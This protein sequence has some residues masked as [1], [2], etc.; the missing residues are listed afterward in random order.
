M[1]R[2]VGYDRYFDRDSIFMALTG[3]RIRRIDETSIIRELK[4]NVNYIL[5]WNRHFWWKEADLVKYFE[6][7]FPGYDIKH[8]FH[9]LGIVHDI[10]RY[11]GA[12]QL[13]DM[14]SNEHEK[15]AKLYAE[16]AT[17]K[18][19]DAIKD[20]IAVTLNTIDALNG[21]LFFEMKDIRQR[22]YRGW[23][24]DDDVTEDLYKKFEAEARMLGK[25]D[26]ETTDIL[27]ERY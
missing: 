12:E 16:F 3:I 17:C 19:S 27:K 14:L 24:D 20:Q 7:K 6:Q 9:R 1:I 21:V 23:S 5:G 26:H 13:F 4:E 25:F 10:V 11:A 15:L 22:E 8:K 18:N 2:Y